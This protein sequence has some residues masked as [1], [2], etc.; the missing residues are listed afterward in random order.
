MFSQK[1]IGVYSVEPNLGKATIA[2]SL[3]KVIAE[4]NTKVLYVEMDYTNPSFFL[5]TQLSHET[6][7]ME[8]LMRRVVLENR[9]DVENYIATRKDF[10]NSNATQLPYSLDCIAF[11]KE[12]DIESFPEFNVDVENQA[13]AFA[14]NFVK[15]LKNL[16]YDAVII[17]LPNRIDSIFGLPLMRKCDEVINILSANPTILSKYI[18]LDSVFKRADMNENEW[19]H[20]FNKC[21]SIVDDKHYINLV[22]FEISNCI[23]FD[24]ERI[25]NEFALK[26]GSVTIDEH[27]KKI[28]RQLGFDVKKEE[29]KFRIF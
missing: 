9:M 24:P 1:I 19:L 12:Y 18:E 29:R 7:N 21:S 14:D 11:G 10:T 3:S 16:G 28:A 27:T 4:A 8:S 22:D 23:P 2:Q 25:E 13:E 5:K 26:I 17:N 15:K 6:K 20:V